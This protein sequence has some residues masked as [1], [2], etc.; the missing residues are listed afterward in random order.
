MSNNKFDE[1]FVNALDELSESLMKVAQL[2]D[3]E[4]YGEDFNT[5]ILA[6]KLGH[7]WGKSLDE[8]AGDIKDV[9]DEMRNEKG[10][11]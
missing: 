10:H 6:I 8:M 9:V 11:K 3:D 7:L 4:I 5:E 2:C 1:R